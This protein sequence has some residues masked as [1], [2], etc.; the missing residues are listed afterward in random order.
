MKKS[1]KNQDFTDF[2]ERFLTEEDCLEYF[3]KIRW[4]RGFVCPYCGKKPCWT[5]APYKYKCRNCGHQTTVTAGT[6]FHR[7]HLTM[8][9]WFKAIYYC[10]EKDDDATAKELKSIAGIGSYRI[11][12]STLENIKLRMYHNDKDKLGWTNNPLDGDVII[13]S[14]PVSINDTNI[15]IIIAVE[16]WAGPISINDTNIDIII[17]TEYSGKKTGRIRIIENEN[18]RTYNEVKRFLESKYITPDSNIIYDFNCTGKILEDFTDWCKG[19]KTNNF[20]VL[21]RSFCRKYSRFNAPVSFDTIL[22][23]MVIN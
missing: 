11:A 10:C 14:G 18:L 23:N 13:W 5:I 20:T 19:K 7:T 15:D 22:E 21:S 12:Q 8:L 16:L 3:K 9:Q 4:K 6:F 17:A 1:S 2:S